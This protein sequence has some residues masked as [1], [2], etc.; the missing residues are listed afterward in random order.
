MSSSTTMPPAVDTEPG[1][2][3]SR[4][5]A[6]PAKTTK[7]RIT[8]NGP[9]STYEVVQFGGPHGKTITRVGPWDFC[10][11]AKNQDRV[12]LMIEDADWM[13]N[14]DFTITIHSPGDYDDFEFPKGSSP[15]GHGWGKHEKGTAVYK[16]ALYEDPGYNPIG[17]RDGKGPY[18]IL[19]LE[20]V[21]GGKV[22][23]RKVGFTFTVV[24]STHEDPEFELE[25]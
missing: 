12:Q 14:Q 7:V 10:L 6:A 15:G 8:P 13:S 18:Q 21:K 19:V 5:A 24:D 22:G 2:K 1:Q 23:G 25:C 16:S 4:Q 3:T 9:D 20:A 17:G 11:N